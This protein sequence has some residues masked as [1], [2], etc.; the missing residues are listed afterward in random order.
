MS[1]LGTVRSM[2]RA[3]SRTALLTVWALTAPPMPEQADVLRACG[4]T[5][6]L[7]AA[8]AGFH[9]TVMTYGQTGSGKTFT[10]SGREDALE[11]DDYAGGTP[12]QAHIQLLLQAGK[13][14]RRCLQR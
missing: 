6:L 13:Q 2:I 10:M 8:L 11:A 3:E 12:D 4:I 1:V 7:D 5:Q 14:T 9:V